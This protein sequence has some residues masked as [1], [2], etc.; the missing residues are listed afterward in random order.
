MHF[1]FGAFD[2]R[3]CVLLIQSRIAQNLWRFSTIC[4]SISLFWFF[5]DSCSEIMVI[6]T[7]SGDVYFIEKALAVSDGRSEINLESGS[8]FVG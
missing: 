5:N 3:F 8:N 2:N 6:G 7:L 4:R 1:F